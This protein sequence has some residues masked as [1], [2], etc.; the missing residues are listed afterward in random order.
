MK[1]NLLK[2]LYKHKKS[3]TKP[4]INSKSNER[5]GLLSNRTTTLITAATTILN[6]N[7]TRLRS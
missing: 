6:I 2:K 7:G 1:N 3:T 5:K 4:V